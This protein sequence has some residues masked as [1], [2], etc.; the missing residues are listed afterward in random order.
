MP[1]DVIALVADIGGT[2]TRVGLAQGPKLLPESIR[3]FRNHEFASLG[4]VLRAYR[5]AERDVVPDA[6]CAAIAGRVRNGAGALTN[7]DW[8]VTAADVAT[9]T[10]VEV[11]QVLNDLQAQ[12]HALGR[13]AP[14]DLREII[15]GKPTG[16]AAQLV[17]GVGTGFNAVPV[18]P[19]DASRLVPSVEAGHV[20]LP[21]RTEEELRLLHFLTEIH[22]YPD[23]EEA[24]SGRGLG[25]I[26]AWLASEDGDAAR[27][28][29]AEIL[30]DAEAGQARACRSLEVFVHLLARVAGDIALSTL[31]FGGIYFSGGMARA[32][33]PWFDRFGFTEEFQSKGRFSSLM[34]E[35]PVF[36]IE[37]DYAALTGCA[38]FLHEAH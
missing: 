3:R 2:N 29:G 9:A 24:L 6:A 10:D 11:A 36:V 34:Q 28:S 37:D 33:A 25:N 4:A 16:D 32:V 1:A 12:G 30:A 8:S 26:Y 31:P 21:V 35:F 14:E 18:Y 13:I 23:I 19:A 27:P 7:L 17:V 20:T 5:E 15:V 38:A 22:G